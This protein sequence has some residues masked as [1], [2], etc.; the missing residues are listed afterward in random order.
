MAR[1]QIGV[2]IYRNEDREPVGSKPIMRD[3]P[4][5]EPVYDAE[6][7]LI[8]VNDHFDYDAAAEF[9]LAEYRRYQKQQMQKGAT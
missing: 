6:G 9:F 7:N 2:I 1:E 5:P 4:D 8:E 3:L